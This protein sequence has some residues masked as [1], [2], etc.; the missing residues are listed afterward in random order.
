[1]NDRNLIEVKTKKTDLVFLEMVVIF[2]CSLLCLVL[3]HISIIQMEKEVIFN[4]ALKERVGTVLGSRVEVTSISRK[5][6]ASYSLL[7]NDTSYDVLEHN[8]STN[9]TDYTEFTCT[10]WVEQDKAL[11]DGYLDS[12]VTDLASIGAYGNYKIYTT[13]SEIKGGQRTAS[14]VEMDKDVRPYTELV[15]GRYG[16]ENS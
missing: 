8:V 7:N 10:L 4:N 1:M 15:V 9:G 6:I 2:T 16:T 12:L 14:A 3:A 5:G 11:T 13:K